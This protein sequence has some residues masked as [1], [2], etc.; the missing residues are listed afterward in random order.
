[1]AL[2]DPNTASR[3]AAIQHDRF[4]GMRITIYL[5][6]SLFHLWE[7][8]FQF[9]PKDH[10]PPDVYRK[11]DPFWPKNFKIDVVKMFRDKIVSKVKSIFN[12]D[13]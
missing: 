3:T 6:R 8:L 5:F 9:D 2:D 11:P 12:D 13:E 7:G 4:Q 10:Y 1:M